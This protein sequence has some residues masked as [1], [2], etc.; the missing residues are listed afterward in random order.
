[1]LWL[2]FKIN[3]HLHSNHQLY[4]DPSQQK[5]RVWWHS[6]EPSFRICF[7]SHQILK[8]ND[9]VVYRFLVRKLYDRIKQR[10]KIS[11]SVLVFSNAGHPEMT[12]EE[13]LAA[14]AQQYAVL[15]NKT[16]GVNIMDK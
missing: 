9:I 8:D 1:M 14:I 15:N 10:N 2:I 4:L 6:Q 13:R 7:L 16:S 11:K 5:M 12:D 3:F